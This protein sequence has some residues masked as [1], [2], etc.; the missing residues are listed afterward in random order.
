MPL[1]ALCTKL[2][3]VRS[4]KHE[5]CE[6]NLFNEILLASLDGLLQNKVTV[7]LF[8]MHKTGPRK[9]MAF[10]VSAGLYN[11]RQR[12]LVKAKVKTSIFI[13]YIYRFS[14]VVDFSSKKYSECS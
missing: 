13:L 11:T 6:T 2:T 10:D 4:G 14:T 9:N 5:A 12:D 3:N 1:P 7:V 8:S